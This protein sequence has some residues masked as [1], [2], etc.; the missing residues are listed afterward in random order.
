[1]IAEVSEEYLSS[2]KTFSRALTDCITLSGQCAGIPAPTSRHTYGAILFTALCTRA[3]SLG[4]MAPRNG[5]TIRQIDH[6]DYVGMFGL[7]R[8]ILEI[9]L[10]FYYI[11]SEECPPAEWGLRWNIFNLHDCCSRMKLFRDLNQNTA[12]IAGFEQQAE[13]IRKRILANRFFKENK[14]NLSAK[15]QRE[16]LSGNNCYLYPLEDIA[17][18]AGISVNSFKIM[19]QLFSNTIHGYP[20]AFYRMMDGERGR[21]VHSAVEDRY[22][23]MA[24]KNAGELLNA[25]LNEMDS[26][27]NKY[28]RM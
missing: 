26:L 3:M 13:E 2:L 19:W 6:W 18:K 15:Q 8:G 22:S 21:G 7:T 27:F 16:L 20:M 4:M 9:R 12:E 24:L 11:C 23:A 1:M 10:A 14:L 5:W 25:T 28:K 17:A